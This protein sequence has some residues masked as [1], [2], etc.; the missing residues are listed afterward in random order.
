MAPPRA[1]IAGPC[2][3]QALRSGTL[4]PE[5]TIRASNLPASDD[6]DED[7]YHNMAQSEH[8]KGHLVHPLAQSQAYPSGP[9]LLGVGALNYLI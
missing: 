3:T 4:L 6:D 1:L 2:T 9:L 5:L 7:Q 8:L